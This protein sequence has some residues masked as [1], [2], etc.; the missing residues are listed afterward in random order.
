MQA[1]EM[2]KQA[3]AGRGEEIKKRADQKAAAETVEAT[4]VNREPGADDDTS[5][6]VDAMDAAG[7]QQ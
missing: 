1:Y 5:G 3:V 7:E 6:F 2:F 4:P